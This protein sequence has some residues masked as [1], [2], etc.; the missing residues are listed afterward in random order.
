MRFLLLLLIAFPVCAQELLPTGARITPTA[1]AGSAFRALNPGLPA[2]PA[3]TA[4]QAVE[5]AVSPDGTTL[6]V[7]TSGFNRNFAADGKFAPG[8]S[9]EYVFVFDITGPQAVQKQALRVANTFLGI[10]WQP[11]GSGFFVSGGVDDDVHVFRRAGAGFAEDGAPVKLGHGAGNGIGTRPV[12]GAVA[13]S[14]DGTRLLVTNVQHDSV[15]LVDVASRLVV[16]ELD[17]RPGKA[18]PAKAGV[19][20]GEYPLSVVWAGDSKAFVAAAR[21]R[22]VV[23]LSVRKDRLAVRRRIAT[24]GQPVKLVLDGARK[25]LFVAADNSDSVVVLDPGDG[26]VASEIPIGLPAG[27]FS[28]PLGLKGVSPN[29]ITVSADGRTLFVTAAG[30]NAVAVVALG[31]EAFEDDDHDAD[32][33]D[34]PSLPRKSRVVGL[35]PTG[36]YPNAAALGPGGRLYAINGKSNAGPNERACLAST[37]GNETSCRAANQYVWQLSKAGLLE[38]PLPSGVELAR[39]TRLVAANNGFNDDGERERGE[40][41]MRFLRQRIRHVVYVV[42]ENRGYDQVLGDLEVGDGDHKLVL[43]PEPVSPNHHAV[44][45]KFVTLDRFMDSGESSNTGWQWSTAARTTDYGEKNAPVN[46]AYRGLQ[47]DFEGSNRNVNVGLPTLAARLQANPNTPADPDVLPGTADVAAPDGPGAPGAGYLWD[48][49]LRAGV[50]IRNYGFYGDLARYTARDATRIP[51]IRDPFAERTRVFFPTKAALLEHSDPYYRGFDM[52]FADFYLVRE[53]QREFAG[54]VA[55]GV[56]PGLTM[57]RLPHD[58]FGAFRDAIDGVNTPELQMAD[59]DYAVGKV[60]ETIAASPFGKETL[61]FVVEDDAQNAADHVD[62]HRSLALIAGPYVKRGAVVS[63]PYTTVN[64]LKTI[65]AVLGIEPMGLNDALAVP[66]S[67]AFETAGDGTWNYVARLP[68]MLFSTQLPLGVERKSGRGA[69]PP[70]MPRHGAD[71]WEEAMAGQDFT[72]EDRLD[73]AKFNAAL[74][75]GLKG[76]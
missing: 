72:Q 4:G 57:L 44:A 11:D 73:T 9:D 45:R 53:W 74:W 25:R 42:K 68:A 64:L 16:A 5:T 35:I 32:D 66:M 29:N 22:E 60:I 8:L 2:L 67:D 31:K 27:V 76:E 21:D 71:Y 48:A 52:R 38:M 6:L 47:Y 65:E 20:G 40:L 19:P 26:D 18:D 69:A 43:F 15:S 55:S 70:P 50:S 13:V 12:A 46:Y 63:R 37:T 62:A 58:H 49:A 23:M 28:N 14:P 24:S 1:A 59:N 30:L 41:V 56:M 39:L 36:W 3:F 51:P 7:L 10:A 75:K 61:V 54:Q 33:D 17:L 34:D